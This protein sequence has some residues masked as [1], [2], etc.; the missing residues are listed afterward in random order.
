VD[1]GALDVPMR[2]VGPEKSLGANMPALRCG[3]CTV[4]MSLDIEG[5]LPP[6]N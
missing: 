2:I 4:F 1:A 6:T 5:R 3:I